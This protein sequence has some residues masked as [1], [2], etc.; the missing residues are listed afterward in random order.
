MG[1]LIDLVILVQDPVAIVV[2]ESVTIGMF[3]HLESVVECF[4]TSLFMTVLNP[5]T[6]T[7]LEATKVNNT[8]RCAMEHFGFF[9]ELLENFSGGN[10]IPFRLAS[11]LSSRI[12]RRPPTWS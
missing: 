12:W 9:L 6:E 5:G 10:G 4:E 1:L 8:N 11:E 7:R 3:S 2:G